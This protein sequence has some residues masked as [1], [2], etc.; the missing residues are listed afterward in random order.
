MNPAI[1]PQAAWTWCEQA[2]ARPGEAE[3]LLR[4]QDANGLDVMF[5]LFERW[6]EECHGI[7]LDAQARAQAEARV[8]PW[9]E[10]VVQPLRALRRRTAE[11]CLH[12]AATGADSAR[13]VRERLKQAELE[14]ERAQLELLC[15]W[16]DHYL[17]R[18]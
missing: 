6:A 7:T 9:R 18:A 5:H 16:L 15:V 2:W 8:R 1:D 12:A 10:G 3:R 11:P 13:T 17:F 14:A 4:E